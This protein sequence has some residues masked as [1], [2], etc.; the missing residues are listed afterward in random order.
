[1]DLV[2]GLVVVP[3]VGVEGWVRGSSLRG[4]HGHPDVSLVSGVARRWCSVQE[5]GGGNNGRSC[6]GPQYRVCIHSRGRKT[7]LSGP[8]VQATWTFNLVRYACQSTV[9]DGHSRTSAR[10]GCRPRAAG[11]RG[12]GLPRLVPGY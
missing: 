7:S 4:D 8:T 1:M 10:A 9:R 2:D 5:V 3:V 6:T 12:P 11:P